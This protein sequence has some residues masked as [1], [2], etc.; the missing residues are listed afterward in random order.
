MRR[1]KL[2]ERNIE[3]RV[4]ELI[5]K[6]IQELGYE[7]YDVEYI[8]EGKEYHLCIYIEKNGIM[9][10]ADCEKVNNAIEPILDDVDLIKEQYFL[11]VSSSG[12][13]K[14]LRKLE[15][16]EKQIGNKIEVKLFT[17]ID[18]KKVIEGILSKV[19]NDCI[20]LQEDE[21]EIKIAFD[22]IASG[23][24]IYEWND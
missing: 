21:K 9:E 2:A 5:E 24:T 20:E 15:H 3:Q 8:K 14:K 6:K 4:Y 22:Q 12:L 18:N 7:L 1:N 10:I 23:K 17:K 16:Y 11:E 13:E 19:E